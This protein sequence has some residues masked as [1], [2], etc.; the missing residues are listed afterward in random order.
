M[1]AAHNMATQH[2]RIAGLKPRHKTMAAFLSLRFGTIRGFA[3]I[4]GRG[5][6]FYAILEDKF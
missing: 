1:V 3:V 5:G 6:K 2:K 4:G